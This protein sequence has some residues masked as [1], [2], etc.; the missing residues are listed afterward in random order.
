[1]KQ[2]FSEN[3]IR[4]WEIVCIW[5]EAYK[6]TQ[7]SRAYMMPVWYPSS[8]A[9]TGNT[10][11]CLSWGQLEIDSDAVTRDNTRGQCW[12]LTQLWGTRDCPPGRET[13][14]ERRKLQLERDKLT[15]GLEH[16]PAHKDEWKAVHF[17]ENHSLDCRWLVEYSHRRM[18]YP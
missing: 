15:H 9:K 7:H 11:V 6:W 12:K 16:V 17:K 10:M 8:E 14:S 18:F 4:P 13:E 5:R 1:M 2:F 3:L